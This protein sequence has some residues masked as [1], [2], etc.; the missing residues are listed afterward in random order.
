MDGDDIGIRAGVVTSRERL[1]RGAAHAALHLVLV[2]DRLLSEPE[3]SL[4]THE[5]ADILTTMIQVVYLVQGSASTITAVDEVPALQPW[6]RRLG[7][8]WRVL[9]G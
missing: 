4:T 6:W 5:A 3:V 7:A 1:S 8:A 2:R 9:R